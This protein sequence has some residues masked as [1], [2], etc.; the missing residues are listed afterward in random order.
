M[1]K[2][3]LVGAVLALVSGAAAANC[4]NKTHVKSLPHMV[5]GK[6]VSTNAYACHIRGD[7]AG[8]FDGNHACKRC[9]C[10]QSSHDNQSV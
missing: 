6:Q 10:P 7:D 1:K 2:L 8:S 4:I 3:L 5:E 9:G